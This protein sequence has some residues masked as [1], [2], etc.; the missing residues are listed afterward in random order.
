MFEAKSAVAVR[1]LLTFLLVAGVMGTITAR[2]FDPARDA[3][4]EMLSR[5]QERMETLINQKR[6][7]NEALRSELHSLEASDYGWQEPARRDLHMLMPGEVVFH[8]PV[9]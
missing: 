9:E 5:Q 7:Q 1:R 8:F 3:R 2:V 4:A 6:Q